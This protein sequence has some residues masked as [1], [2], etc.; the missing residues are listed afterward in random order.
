MAGWRGAE[1]PA[2]EAV[3]ERMRAMARPCSSNVVVNSWVPLPRETKKSALVE[4]SGWS[5]ARIA[6]R[7]GLQIGPG[8]RPKTT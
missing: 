7:P 4:R 5:A 3:A 6:A 2:S 1:S 8:G